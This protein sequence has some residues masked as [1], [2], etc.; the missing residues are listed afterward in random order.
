MLG[1][2]VSTLQDK[3]TV[4]DRAITGE[5]Y[6]TEDYTEFS[7]DPELQKGYF[8][9]LKWPDPEEGVTSL[10]IGIVPSSIG[11][12]LQEAIDDQDRNGVFRITDPDS[13]VVVIRQSDG[14]KTTTQRFDLNGVTLVR[15]N[16]GA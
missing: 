14:T 8:L 1:K 16:L 6:Y 2:T 12:D 3:I 9:V 5:V 11:A 7:G 13:Q 15:E 4:G 10:K